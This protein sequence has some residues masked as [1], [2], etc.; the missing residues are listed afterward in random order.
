MVML[1]SLGD[2][3]TFPLDYALRYSDQKLGASSLFIILNY[4]ESELEMYRPVQ[5][6]DESVGR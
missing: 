1:S 5:K 3:M 6:R 2:L 4:I